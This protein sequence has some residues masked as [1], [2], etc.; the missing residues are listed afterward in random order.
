VSEC[1]D[2]DDDVEN[3][4]VVHMLWMGGWM[5]RH[6]IPSLFSLDPYRCSWLLSKVEYCT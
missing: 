2:V 6:G 4:T 5:D 3:M 1:I